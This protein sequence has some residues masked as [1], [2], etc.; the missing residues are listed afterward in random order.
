MDPSLTGSQPFF[1]PLSR[2]VGRLSC[3]N[4]TMAEED[5]RAGSAG[6]H[7]SC[8]MKGL[9]NH[10]RAIDVLETLPYAD[11]GRL[12]S[13]GHSLGGHNSIFAAVFDPRIKV[14][15]ASC[16]WTPWAYYATAQR[17][18]NT[19]WALPKYMPR[20]KTA[21]GGDPV[22]IPV[23][24]YE[25]VA[26]IA[27]RPFFSNSPVTDFNFNVTGVWAAARPISAVWARYAAAN[28]NATDLGDRF[29]IEFPQ[30]GC[31]IHT[32]AGAG[33]PECGHDFPDG[34]RLAAYAFIKRHL[35]VP[36][37]APFPA[38]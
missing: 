38:I 4:C 36:P 33:Q 7:A 15:V 22:R 21:F 30:G 28:L 8:T 3:Y 23:D 19:T 13:I 17:P 31:A 12:A 27:P 10:I 9:V 26:A 5:A 37:D 1:A 35:S 32:Y 16:G 34:T 11:V 18:L 25:L 20:I 29:T 6:G 2:A 24:F 14:V